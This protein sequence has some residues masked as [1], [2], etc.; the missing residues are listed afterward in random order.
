MPAWVEV[1][2]S[3]LVAVGTGALAV[4][5]LLMARNGSKQ[6]SWLVEQDKAARTPRVY[7]EEALVRFANSPSLGGPI[8]VIEARGFVNLGSH[9]IL[10]ESVTLQSSRGE[11]V[12]QSLASVVVMP[13]DRLPK[14]STAYA[15]RLV[16][17]P[18]RDD[19][20]DELAAA[21]ALEVCFQT[22]SDP[23]SL[24]AIRL[25]RMP[26]RDNSLVYGGRGAAPYRLPPPT[27]P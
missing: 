9:G 3:L 13:G 26:P 27:F 19:S 10:I 8:V 24:W 5:T 16:T 11:A 17:A 7:F 21:E 12:F 4:V 2:A 25:D 15:E 18:M 1:W 23:Q 22:G 14:S 20:R 6:L